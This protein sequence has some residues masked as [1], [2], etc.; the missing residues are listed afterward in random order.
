[1][2]ST[3]LF[4]ASLSAV[5][6]R[7]DLGAETILADVSVTIG[8]QS[9]MGIVGSNGAGKT[10]L[11]RLLAGFDPPDG[12]RIELS[13][14]DAIVGYLAQI[15]LRPSSTIGEHLMERTGLV[16]AEQE[17]QAAAEGLADGG[18]GASARYEL[19]LARWTAQD[20]GGAQARIETA[21]EGAGLDASFLERPMDRLSG[22]QAAKVAL[23]GVM[24]APFDIML[25]DEPTNDLDFDGIDRLE[26]FLRSRQGGL[27]VVSHDRAFLERSIDSVLE[28]DAHHRTARLFQ[29]GWSSYL[30]EQALV[31]RHDE[32]RFA[33]YSG[34]RQDLVDRAQR[35]RLWSTSGARKA[36]ARPTD[37][38]KFVRHFKTEKSE[39]LA[40]RGAT[41]RERHGAPG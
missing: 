33:E 11:L 22:G 6:L 9:K 15:P 7:R 13:P 23:A 10:T 30:E 34:R 12:G 25:L 2:R 35:E 3:A 14:P 8:P 27:A 18:P 1:M 39:Q 16:A 24:A 19:A 32:E 28:L 38:D 29:G 41:H 31:R 20:S 21:L 4:S 17:L 40:A 5:H 36:K 37:G 26:R